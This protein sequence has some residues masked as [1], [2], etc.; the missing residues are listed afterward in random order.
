MQ[1]HYDPEADA[2]YVR[3]AEPETSVRTERLDR[4][5]LVDYDAQSEPVGVEFLFV[6]EGISF[7]GVPRAKEIREALHSLSAL[8]PA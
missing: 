2:I 7:V 8:A 4:R 6:S 5:R 3:F 1:L